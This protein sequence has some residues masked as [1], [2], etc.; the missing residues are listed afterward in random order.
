MGRWHS[1]ASLPSPPPATPR[2]DPRHR[3]RLHALDDALIAAVAIGL[4]IAASL[5]VAAPWLPPLRYL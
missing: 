2:V 1:S 5:L 4:L 3:G